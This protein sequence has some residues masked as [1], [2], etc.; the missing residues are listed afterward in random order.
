MIIGMQQIHFRNKLYFSR[1]SVCIFSDKIVLYFAK[2]S[3][4]HA[5]FNDTIK[6]MGHHAMFRATSRVKLSILHMKKLF[7]FLWMKRNLWDKK[8][9]IRYEKKDLWYAL[10]IT[11]NYWKQETRPHRYL[12]KIRYKWAWR[13][14]L[15]INIYD[16]KT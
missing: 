12:D 10:R 13:Y 16:I 14:I 11:I 1:S 4:Y 6:S 7:F 2:Y 9:K 3:L 5:F 15:D 8:N